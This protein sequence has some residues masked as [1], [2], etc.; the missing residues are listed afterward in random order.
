MKLA[1]VVRY[2]SREDIQQA[3]I[4]VAR[5]REVAGVYRSGDYSKR[6]NTL[7]YPQDI[8]AMVRSGVLEFHSSIERWTNPMGIKPDNYADVRM[9]WD[10]VLDLDCKDFEHGKIASSVF[11]KALEKHDIKN[12]SLKFTGGTGFHI[13]IPWETIPKTIDYKDSVV[14]FPD[15]ARN[16]GLYIKSFVREGFEC[17]LLKKYSP[18]E[19]ADQIKEPLGKLFD[20]DAFDPF[21]VVD[22]DPILISP[23]HLFRMPYSLNKKKWLVSLPLRASDLDDFQMEDATADKVK[24]KLGFLDSGEENESQLLIS[25]AIDWVI[26]QK[27]ETRK[28]K[29]R[30][31]AAF[32]GA[33]PR[34]DF[35]VCI[36]QIL[37]GL[38]DGKKR[39][40]FILI[41]FLRSC[42]WAWNDIETTIEEWNLKNS[43]QL[44]ENYIRG[45]LR[46]HRQ[47][48]RKILPPNYE[49][50]GW[51]IDIGLND[52]ETEKLKNPVNVAVKNYFDK[53]KK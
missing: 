35:P 24:P 19:L 13:G 22:V 27:K 50:K 39:S 21:Q 10:I 15:L 9:G 53:R 3:M 1:E 12:Y 25:E 11:C 43:P 38:Q 45:Q 29:R 14:L 26:R 31:R 47:Q 18:E 16:I 46:W 37:N 5:N 52:P 2:Y 49:A 40:L 30:E 42:G 17:A 41:T 4:R 32:K 44:R 36:Q 6:P 33:I 7:I 23:R 48:K 51:Y 28:R 8:K 20:G 34:E